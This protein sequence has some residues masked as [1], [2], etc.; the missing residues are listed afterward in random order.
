MAIKQVWVERYRP[1]SVARI[2]MPS[3]RLRKTF[4]AWVEAGEIPNILM[5][6]GPGTGKTSLSLALL[7]DIGVQKQDTLRINCSDEK[8]DALR[9]KVKGFATTM[10]IGNFKVVRLEEFDYLNHDAQ[11]LLRALMEDVSDSCR[12]IA[13][14][15][16][17]GKLTPPLRS[18]FQEFQI[19]APQREDALVLAAEILEAEHVSFELEDVDKIVAASYP[20]LRKMIQLLEGNTYAGK[21]DL[22]VAQGVSDWKLDLL[23]ALEASDLK[24][25]RKI[26]CESATIEELQDV[27][28]FLYDNLHRVN[29]LG[30]NLDEAIVLLAEYQYKHAFAADKEINTAALFIELNNLTK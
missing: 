25:A 1:K 15:N 11:A 22:A 3:E 20:D 18:R 19:A 14:C 29:R 7:R 23:P 13:T 10:P 6:G 9:D 28:R 27:F 2:I 8:I 24:A 12:F 26:V 30:K 17:I 4:A 5:Y 21:L 16:Y